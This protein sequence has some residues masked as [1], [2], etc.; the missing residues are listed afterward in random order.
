[1]IED[2]LV[3]AGAPP[4]NMMERPRSNLIGDSEASHLYSCA[5]RDMTKRPR[6]IMRRAQQQ[7]HCRRCA[8]LPWD[9]VALVLFWS[10]RQRRF[11]RLACLTSKQSARLC[12]AFRKGK[13]GP[14]LVRDNQATTCRTR[15]PADRVASTRNFEN[16]IKRRLLASQ[17]CQKDTGM[18]R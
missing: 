14:E 3:P 1:M 16:S 5:D 11:N 17:S 13:L 9:P 15:G 8:E 2:D 12:C 10:M 18:W 6:A 4:S 7:Y